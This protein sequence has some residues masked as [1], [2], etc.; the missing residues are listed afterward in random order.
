MGRTH[1]VSF[2]DKKLI[3][4]IATPEILTPLVPRIGTIAEGIREMREHAQEI[5]TLGKFV[6]ATGFTPGREFQLVASIPYS[7]KA[8]IIAVIPD[9][10]ENKKTFYELLAGPLKDYDRRGKIVL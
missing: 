6:K 7:V 10:F 8:A 5:T 1:M 2:A 3:S 4:E 9:A